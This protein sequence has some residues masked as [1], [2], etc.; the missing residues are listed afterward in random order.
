MMHEFKKSFVQNINNEIYSIAKFGDGTLIAG[1]Q[2]GLVIKF[3]GDGVI[4]KAKK[5]G[6]SHI[7]DM[8][9]GGQ[10]SVYMATFRSLKVYNKALS[11]RIQLYR[12]VEGSND[13]KI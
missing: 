5:I 4:K 9:I 8:V 13:C 10:D 1:G 12:V 11:R 6:T 3:N 2:V 7:L